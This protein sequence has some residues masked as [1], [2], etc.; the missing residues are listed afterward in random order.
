MSAK[1][2]KPRKAFKLGD[3]LIRA[4]REFETYGTFYDRDVR[5]LRIRVGDWQYDGS[6][7][8]ELENIRNNIL[9]GSSHEIQ[10]RRDRFS[11]AN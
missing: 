1:N 10:S 6:V 2:A 11:S 3:E 8:A 5:G 9:L 4:Q 7:R